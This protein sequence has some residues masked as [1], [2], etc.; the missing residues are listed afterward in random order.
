MSMR[1]RVV[2]SGLGVL[3]PCG[4]GWQP[5]WDALLRPIS[6]LRKISNLPGGGLFGALAGEVP[7]FDPLEFVSNRKSLKLMSRE[8]QLGVAASALAHRD[9]GLSLEQ[10]DRDRIGI[11]LGTGIINNDLDEVGAG[12]L[13][14]FDDQG[15]FHMEKFGEAGI[16]ALFPLW[17]LKY[18]PNMPACHISI[19]LG[20]RGPSNTLTASAA[21]A[22]HAVGEAFRIIERGDA[23]C[24]FAG[25]TDSK[26]NA[27]GI[28]RFHLLK[29]LAERKNDL[30]RI[31]CPFD[32]DHSGLLLGEGA[33]LVVLEELDHALKRGA[34]VYA[35]VFG[36]GT[37]AECE[38]YTFE[39]RAAEGKLAAMGAAL[40]DARIKP[41]DVDFILA[42]GSGIPSEDESEA[43]AIR[44]LFEGHFGNLRVTGLK[45]VTGH[46]VYASAGIEIAAAALALK[47]G[48]LPPLLHLRKPAKGC[49]LPFVTGTPEKRSMRYGFLNA[50]GFGGQNAVLVLGRF[51]GK[52]TG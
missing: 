37:S 35:E 1:R 14:G 3:S 32:Q 39:T 2:I 25:G 8:I 51:D 44:T 47:H 43:E 28:S 34:T 19:A 27:M 30:E 31:Y 50:F 38:T 7:D 15:N 29:L 36:Y 46:L 17:F 20:L 11:S 49:G 10:E 16:R 12:I 13:K 22:A 18:L 33:G 21:A 40:Q 23:D 45:P 5:Y 41:R 4:K 42:N 48:C 6:C 26:I 24:M 9:S 52:E